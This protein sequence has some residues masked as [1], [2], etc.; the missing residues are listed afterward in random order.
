MQWECPSCLNLFDSRIYSACPNCPDMVNRC[1][2]PMRAWPKTLAEWCERCDIP[3]QT[4]PAGNVYVI[5][6]R[7]TN[8]Y[9]TALWHLTDYAVAGNGGADIFFLKLINNHLTRPGSHGKVM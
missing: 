9:H 3:K 8:P 1:L 7:M 6:D 4:S 2:V 5:S